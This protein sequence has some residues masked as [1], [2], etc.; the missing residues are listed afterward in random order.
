MASIPEEVKTSVCDNKML[1]SSDIQIEGKVHFYDTGCPIWMKCE[2]CPLDVC[3]DEVLIEIDSEW[4]KKMASYCQE[5]IITMCDK[6]L[7]L[8][9]ALI[10]LKKSKK[11]Y[12]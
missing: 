4:V 3:I 9:K 5:A 6:Y 2:L 11:C 1:K 12:R 10:E 8:V 7:E